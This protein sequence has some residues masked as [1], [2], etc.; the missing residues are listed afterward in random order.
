MT[1]TFDFSIFELS[2]VS[3]SPRLTHKACCETRF[4]N[5]GKTSILFRR[6]CVLWVGAAAWQHQRH[7][8][9]WGQSNSAVVGG[10]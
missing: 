8:S 1:H 7:E 6:R 5:K 4:E 9:L 2:F 10:K 3:G